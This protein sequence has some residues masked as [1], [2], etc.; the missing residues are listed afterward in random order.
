MKWIKENFP[1]KTLLN[2]IKFAFISNI[3]VGA[4][5]LVKIFEI[6]LY[7]SNITKFRVN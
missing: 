3:P 5:Q 1:H 4:A 7:L 6:I 2:I